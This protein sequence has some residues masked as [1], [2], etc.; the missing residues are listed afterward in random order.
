MLMRIVIT[1]A[2]VLTVSLALVTREMREREFFRQLEGINVDSILINRRLIDKYIKCL[3]KTGKCDPTMKD[4][5]IALPLILEHLCETRCSERERQNLRKLFLYIRTNRAQEWERLAKLYDPKGAYKA[6]VDAFIENRPRPTMITSSAIRETVAP[7]IFT[8]TTTTTTT[9]TRAPTAPP[10]QRQ[11]IRATR[12]ALY[13]AMRRFA[14]W[15]NP[16]QP[17]KTTNNQLNIL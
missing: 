15:L 16:N 4:L 14:M 9:T 11:S 13:I 10:P 17:A 1:I 2:A 8:T 7:T 6:N 5:R 3:L 12:N